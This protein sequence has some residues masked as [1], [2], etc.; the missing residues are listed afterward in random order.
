MD[1]VTGQLHLIDVPHVNANR[2]KRLSRWLSLHWGPVVVG[3]VVL[4]LLAL[5]MWTA[6]SPAALG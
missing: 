5:V 4:L 6:F 2:A 3:G 1:C